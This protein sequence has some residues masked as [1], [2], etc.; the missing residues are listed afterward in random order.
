MFSY[1]T[2]AVANR[3]VYSPAGSSLP[4]MSPFP[5]TSPGMGVISPVNNVSMTD[6]EDLISDLE[7]DISILP[8]C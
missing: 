6:L 7:T 3:W 4:G 2:N 5:V 8:V 1:N